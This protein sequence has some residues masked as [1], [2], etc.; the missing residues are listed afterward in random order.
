MRDLL[1]GNNN[2]APATY[3]VAATLAATNFLTD[4]DKYLLF[5]I[6]N[7]EMALDKALTQNPGW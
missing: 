2:K 7:S 3:L 1:T 5:P 6:P 4:P